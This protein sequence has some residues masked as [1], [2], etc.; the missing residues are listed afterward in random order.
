MTTQMKPPKHK[1]RSVRSRQTVTSDASA[2]DL[3]MQLMAIEGGSGKEGQVSEFICQQLR[4]SGAPTRSITVDRANRRTPIR[5]ETGNL[6]FRLPGTIRSPRRLLMA[7]MD[8]VPICI[9]AQ[10]VRRDGFIVSKNRHTGLGADDRAGCGV[11]LN[12]AMQILRRN[13]PH[14]P[15]S[16]CWTIQEET[17]LHGA[18]HLNISL[19]GQPRLAFNWDGG[20]PEKMTIGATGGYRMSIEIRGIASHAGG[21]PEHGISA[22][23]V[24]ALAISDLVRRGWHGDVRKGRKRGTSNIGVIRGGEATNVVTERVAI[25]AEARSHDPVFRRKILREIERAFQRAARQTRNVAGA[26]A[27]VDID[28]RLDYESFQL[29]PDEPCVHAAEAAV[30]TTGRAPIR[31]IANGGVD[32]NWMVARGIPTVTLGCGQANAHTANEALNITA[33]LDAC[34]IALCLAMATETGDGT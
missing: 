20:S 8:T 11:I 31:A 2:V 14:P 23:A 15:L 9:G 34:R 27:N 26:C 25:R 32:A 18:H 12:A 22:I 28:T 16:F 30:R 6:V 24:A 19:L 3:V 13:L 29:G 17:G 4:Q 5:G 1:R 33:Y 21:A 10:P 7:H